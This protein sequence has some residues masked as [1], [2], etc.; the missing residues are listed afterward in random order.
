M[1]RELAC[2]HVIPG[3]I[4]QGVEPDHA[5]VAI[6]IEDCRFTAAVMHDLIISFTHYLPGINHPHHPVPLMIHKEI[7]RFAIQQLPVEDLIETKLPIET[8]PH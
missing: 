1:S 7:K 8:L 2:L 6:N 5:L 4:P 3:P